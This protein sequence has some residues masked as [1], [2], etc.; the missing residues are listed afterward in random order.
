M[1]P[2]F[3]DL[4]FNIDDPSCVWHQKASALRDLQELGTDADGCFPSLKPTLSDTNLRVRS[5]GAQACAALSIP[6]VWGRLPGKM[7][8]QVLPELARCMSDVDPATRRVAREPFN[9]LKA[10]GHLGE[11]G[12]GALPVLPDL[13]RQLEDE[14]WRIRESAARVFPELGPTGIPACSA[15]VRLIADEANNCREMAKSS[16]DSLV[17]VGFVAA[18]LRVVVPPSAQH[19]RMRLTSKNWKVK[20]AAAWALGTGATG[21]VMNARRLAEIVQR[22]PNQH[23]RILAVEVLGRLGL[24]CLPALPVVANIYGVLKTAEIYG[25]LKKGT[26][27]PTDPALRKACH[28]TLYIVRSEMV[29]IIGKAMP[30]HQETQKAVEKAQRAA[31]RFGCD[32]QYERELAI[33]Q[34]CTANSMHIAAVTEM[35]KVLLDPTCPG[36]QA[37]GSMTSAAEAIK[38]TFDAGLLGAFDTENEGTN[39]TSGLIKLMKDRKWRVRLAAA[40]AVA[41]QAAF[42]RRPVA[43]IQ[44]HAESEDESMRVAAKRVL[45]LLQRDCA[46]LD[47]FALAKKAAPEL[48]YVNSHDF[49]LDCDGV[50]VN[51]LVMAQK[52]A[53]EALKK[54][55][56][57]KLI[58]QVAKDDLEDRIAEPPATQK[59]SFVA[60]KPK[61]RG[62]LPKRG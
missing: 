2:S 54:L 40:E 23:V 13:I 50:P 7:G 42:L 46:C 53:R 49:V 14:D 5:A 47:P 31:I 29:S 55:I 18:D 30:K 52:V 6:D 60:T 44:H 4:L 57:S 25:E 11:V 26:T 56:Q 19:L 39:I 20:C 16:L 15:L 17:D 59:V 32:T 45:R 1:A 58:E 34:L 28:D 43:R 24:A 38:A 3:P 61:T 33:K 62:S 8:S 41:S 22:E 51:D 9:E 21:A 36:A 37:E 10:S 12:V 35:L 27:R 48:R